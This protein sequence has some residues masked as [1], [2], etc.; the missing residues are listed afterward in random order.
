MFLKTY[1]S[2]VRVAQNLE[3]YSQGSQLG[4]CGREITTLKNNK[5]LISAIRDSKS[6]LPLNMQYYSFGEKHQPDVMESIHLNP[7]LA[8]SS[9]M[10]PPSGYTSKFNGRYTNE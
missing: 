7:I 2:W 4:E 10:E 9:R 5:N 6:E 3:K 8:R 1:S